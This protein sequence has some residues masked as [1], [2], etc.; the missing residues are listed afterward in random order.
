MSPSTLL[1][2]ALSVTTLTSAT[3]FK[4]VAVPNSLNFNAAVKPYF[5]SLTK[6]LLT[7]HPKNQ[8]RLK[9]SSLQDPL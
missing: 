5:R 6:L 2:L 9:N 3:A 7:P 4:Q 1:A 8:S